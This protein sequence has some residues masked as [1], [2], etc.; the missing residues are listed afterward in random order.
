M[1]CSTVTARGVISQEE[2]VRLVFS[3]VEEHFDHSQ[4]II[5]WVSCF[6]SLGRSFSFFA[7]AY[8]AS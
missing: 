6:A 4:R 1:K 2:L 7:A 5:R 3:E 8:H